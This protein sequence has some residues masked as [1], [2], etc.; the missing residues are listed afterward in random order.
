MENVHWIR[1]FGLDKS[2]CPA[3]VTMMLRWT[4]YCLRSRFCSSLHKHWMYGLSSSGSCLPILAQF[5]IFILLNIIHRILIYGGLT[6]TARI[7]LQIYAN[8][9]LAS[10]SPTPVRTVECWWPFLPLVQTILAPA[11]ND[12]SLRA[13]LRAL[14][15]VSDVNAPLVWCSWTCTMEQAPGLDHNHVTNRVQCIARSAW[16]VTFPRVY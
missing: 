7:K 5:W 10:T 2:N 14:W 3:S 8:F 9:T 1:L 16:S 4:L 15:I 11:I 6:R 12:S 13:M